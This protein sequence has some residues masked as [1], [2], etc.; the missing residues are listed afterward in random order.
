MEMIYERFIWSVKKNYPKNQD[1]ILEAYKLKI[2]LIEQL[3]NG[4]MIYKYGYKI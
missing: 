2:S 1:K 3:Q 4:T